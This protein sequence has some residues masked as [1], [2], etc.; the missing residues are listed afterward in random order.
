MKKNLSLGIEG[1]GII[2]NAL[3]TMIGVLGVLGAVVN[4]AACPESVP[5]VRCSNAAGKSGLLVAYGLTAAGA[6][7]L[8][9]LAGR[10]LDPEA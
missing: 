8:V 10:A 4:V 7:G 3:G 6:G 5:A 1:A 9:I 2:A